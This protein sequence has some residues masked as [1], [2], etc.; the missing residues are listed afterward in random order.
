MA[1]VFDDAGLTS[2][3]DRWRRKVD[4]AE[5][6]K[7]AFAGWW[8]VRWLR[9]PTAWGS[10]WL[11]RHPYLAIA[12]RVLWLVAGTGAIYHFGV[13]RIAGVLGIRLT[14]MIG[15]VAFV[16][17]YVATLVF[18][19]R[20][21]G[22]RLWRPA[23]AA[24]IVGLSFGVYWL[25]TTATFHYV[26]GVAVWS[27]ELWA[28]IELAWRQDVNFAWS[29]A[30][31]WVGWTLAW[32]FT[33]G[34]VWIRA[35]RVWL[36]IRKWG[37]W[38]MLWIVRLVI[39]G[40]VA[41]FIA[42][43]M[44]T[45]PVDILVIY[46]NAISSLPYVGETLGKATPWPLLIVGA[47]F[48][49]ICV[50][51]FAVVGNMV[52]DIL[53]IIAKLL[54]IAYHGGIIFADRVEPAKPIK[55]VGL[56][57]VVRRWHEARER[58][59]IRLQKISRQSLDDRRERQLQREALS[60]IGPDGF[61][62][63]PLPPDPHDAPVVSSAVGS[64]NGV[65]G[66][67][68]PV[69]GS[70]PAPEAAPQPEPRPEPGTAGD[71]D[72]VDGVV[73]PP[74]DTPGRDAE[75]E[76]ESPGAPAPDVGA[77][78]AALATAKAREQEEFAAEQAREGIVAEY[79]FKMKLEYGADA[80][81]A[82]DDEELLGDSE[83]D[84]ALNDDPFNPDVAEDYSDEHGGGDDGWNPMPDE[85][86][87]Q[88]EKDRKFGV[89]YSEVDGEEEDVADEVDS[90]HADPHVV[91]V[92]VPAQSAERQ[93]PDLEEDD[94]DEV[95]DD[96]ADPHV[97]VA[98][99][100]ASPD[101]SLPESADPGASEPAPGSGAEARDS[102]DVDVEGD[103]DDGF[104]DDDTGP[105]AAVRDLS[106]PEHEDPE[107]VGGSPSSGPPVVVEDGRP[108]GEVAPS[109]SHDAH[110]D[111]EAGEPVGDSPSAP[112]APDVGASWDP[113]AGTDA[114]DDVELIERLSSRGTSAVPESS[115]D[116]LDDPREGPEVFL[117]PPEGW[118][119]GET[120]SF[121][122]DG[123]VPV[124]ANEGEGGEVQPMGDRG[125]GMPHAPG[126]DEPLCDVPD[127]ADVDPGDPA[128]MRAFQDALNLRSWQEQQARILGAAAA[129]EIPA[130]EGLPV[131]Q[132]SRRRFDVLEVGEV[133]SSLS[134]LPP[135]LFVR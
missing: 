9:A 49:S 92:D 69:P 103:D 34:L 20:V 62:L 63:F 29:A 68:A 86:E 3:G 53:S 113:W 55:V 132:G 4:H 85:G 128:A 5:A 90:D 10:A 32:V 133:R 112:V 114:G 75:L 110:V 107:L 6:W 79:E 35:P 51:L 97:V 117:D 111:D 26:Y 30:A 45:A 130:G 125:T 17:A 12:C 119:E 121:S 38:L 87:V 73:A 16:V 15:V 48:G 96:N 74:V 40:A 61:T 135:G 116:D 131:G 7:H 65:E 100:A 104:G 11:A 33:L 101:L 76:S 122:S 57:V 43:W 56:E 124:P 50:F 60:D 134:D 129:A 95:G 66:P 8:V 52:A 47:V 13:D 64:G 71:E 98:E 42:G 81:A 115:V 94:D 2:M 18:A 118:R 44:G 84:R 27:P 58:R 108:S 127:A 39:F 102:L 36:A 105:A 21:G 123:P 106:R 93:V 126:G 82:A 19:L 83:Y 91:L 28:D 59:G 31:W 80:D 70:D 41:L 120:I 14:G 25:A 99:A 72:D 77:E 78:T 46:A 1:S 24:A 109:E 23:K 22:N 67:A 88:A 89:A 37:I 54:S